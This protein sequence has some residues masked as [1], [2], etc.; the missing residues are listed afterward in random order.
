MEEIRRAKT[1]DA[2]RIQEIIKKYAKDADLLVRPLADIYSH[3]RDYFVAV[4]GKKVEG[5]ISLHVYW[6]DLAEIRSFV[7]EKKLRG[8]GSGKKLLDAALTEARELGIKRVFA[9]TKIPDYFRKHGFKDI[10]K[11]ELPQKIW[12]DCFNCPKFPD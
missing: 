12:K 5:V 7:L 4:T 8:T 11:K 2:A 10:D 9:L 1:G 3:I 6:E